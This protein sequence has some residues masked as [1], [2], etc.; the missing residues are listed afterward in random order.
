MKRLLAT[1][2]ALVVLVTLVPAANAAQG[3]TAATLTG[4]YAF[5][6]SGFF[7]N[8]GRNSPISG[9]GS[10][11]LD[12]KGNVS[13]TVTA[14]FDGNL[15]TFPYTATYTV[16]PDCTGSVTATPGSGLANFSIVIVR[17]GAEVLGAEIDPGNTWTIDFKKQN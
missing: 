5:T 11:T 16:N 14:S 15:S 1:I 9:I 2:F 13:A 12:G 6:F 3:C 8:Q 7:Q 10:G 4:S 17:G